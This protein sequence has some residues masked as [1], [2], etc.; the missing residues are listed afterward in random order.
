VIEVVGY[1][2]GGWWGSMLVVSDA[3]IQRMKVSAVRM[4]RPDKKSTQIGHP[5]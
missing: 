3:Q 4:V 1:R 5:E 2:T